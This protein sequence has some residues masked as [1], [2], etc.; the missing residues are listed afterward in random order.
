MA[1]MI[2]HHKAF[3]LMEEGRVRGVERIGAVDAAGRDDADGRLLLFHHAHLHGRGLR[4]EQNVVTPHG[5][6]EFPRTLSTATTST[7]PR[8][9][10]AVSP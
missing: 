2:L 8:S 6:Q 4:A 1:H 9:S 7:F 3:H 10:Q 5:R